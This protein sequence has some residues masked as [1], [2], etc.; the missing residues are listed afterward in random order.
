MIVRAG[1]EIH[2]RVRGDVDRGTTRSAVVESTGSQRGEYRLECDGMAIRLLPERA[3]L[4][5][6]SCAIVSC[7]LSRLAD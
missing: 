7:H 2:D 3:L 4:A 1:A 6:L 5:C